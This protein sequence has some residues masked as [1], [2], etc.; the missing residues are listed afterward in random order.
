M[1]SYKIK[2][3]VSPDAAER[4]REI[5]RI[6]VDAKLALSPGKAADL[7][8]PNIGDVDL[9]NAYYV[10]VANYRFSDSPSTNLR[11]LQMA[12]AGL[13]V[14]VGCSKIPRDMEYLA[15]VITV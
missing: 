6:L 4:T 11:L 15:D 3:V 5:R 13:L 9:R 12:A 1:K 2:A 8:R 10:A 14:V 7:I